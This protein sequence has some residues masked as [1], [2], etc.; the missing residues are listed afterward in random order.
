MR[1]PDA[2]GVAVRSS[3]TIWYKSQLGKSGLNFL[4]FEI[5]SNQ[6][7]RHLNRVY[8]LVPI[9]VFLPIPRRGLEKTRMSKPRRRRLTSV[10]LVSF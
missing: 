3:L 2:R 6:M 1:M 9:A 10:P 5:N 7:R 8:D 4:G